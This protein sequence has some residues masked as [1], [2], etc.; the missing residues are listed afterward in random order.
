LVNQ[1]VEARRGSGYLDTSSLSKKQLIDLWEFA[2][3]EIDRANRNIDHFN[4]PGGPIGG[5]TAEYLVG[6]H[7]LEVRFFNLVATQIERMVPAEELDAEICQL[8]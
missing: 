6:K 3:F 8:F 2:R 5:E 1:L 7:K 4:V